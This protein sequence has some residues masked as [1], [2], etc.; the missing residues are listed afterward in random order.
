MAPQGSKRWYQLVQKF[1]MAPRWMRLSSAAPAR[2]GQLAPKLWRAVG[3]PRRSSSSRVGME[4][5][6]SSHPTKRMPPQEAGKVGR[7]SFPI[8]KKR[9]KHLTLRDGSR[10]TLQERRSRGHK[11]V[12]AA[13]SMSN[14]QAQ[15]HLESCCCHSSQP[16]H[17]ASLLSGRKLSSR[18]L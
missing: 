4:M 17:V 7:H 10:R 13:L 16:C 9:S 6:L 12:R 5:C 1:S 3:A 14:N 2:L 18:K 8:A 15:G 11:I